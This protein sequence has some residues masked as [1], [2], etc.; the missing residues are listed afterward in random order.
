[1]ST[2]PVRAA[3]SM[4]PSRLVYVDDTQPG[5]TRIAHGDGFAYVDPH[6]RPITDR[7]SLDR[8]ARLAVP[9]AYVDVWICPDPRGHIQAT[10]RD[11]RGR[12]QYRYHPAWNAAR[13]TSKFA[14]MIAFAAALP[15]LRARIDADLAAP[16]V[17]R[18]RVLATVVRLL[19]LTLIRVGNDEYARRN[20]SFGMTTLEARHVRT[21]GTTISFAF[22][23]KSGVRHVRSIRDRRLA[24]TVRRLQELPG[25]RLFQYRAADATLH[26]VTSGDINEYLRTI[27]GKR[28]T[29]KDFRTFA[30]TTAAAVALAQAPPAGSETAARR[31]IAA[32]LREVAAA[33]GNTQAVC[34]KAYVHPGVL[35]A[36]AA[37][38]IP[39][40]IADVD[41]ADHAMHM[42]RFLRRIHR[43]TTAT[44]APAAR[45]APPRS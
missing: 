33:L 21:D 35:A 29:A 44:Y 1:M 11:A 27:S 24:A 32:C 37:G 9:P 5:I 12:K 19:E 15:A 31:T 45:R 41:A 42:L 4:A 14:Q 34:R 13:S 6:G 7:R 38:S 25:Q 23:G 40:A 26:A 28:F 3:R 8:L 10:A 18:S 22:N 20:R 43:Q 36:Y 17:T 30:G 2:P 39:A 16:G